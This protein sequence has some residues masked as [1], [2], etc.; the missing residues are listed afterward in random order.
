MIALVKVLRLEALSGYRLRIDFSDGS[1]GDYDFA[2]MIAA[3]GTMVEP[4]RDPAFFARVFV[5]NGV[6]AWPNGF[7]IDSIALHREM[8]AAGALAPEVATA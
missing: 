7:D 8:K 2:D 5:Q 3:G 6:P 4:L 1:V